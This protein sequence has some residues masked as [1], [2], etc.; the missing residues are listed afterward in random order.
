MNYLGFENLHNRIQAMIIFVRWRFSHQ[1]RLIW[2]VG[3]T[4]VFNH[5]SLILSGIGCRTWMAELYGSH[6][7]RVDQGLNFDQERIM[8]LNYTYIMLSSA[9]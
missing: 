3:A 7:Q 9:I 2:G 8:V 1:T 6:P 4:Y 5:K